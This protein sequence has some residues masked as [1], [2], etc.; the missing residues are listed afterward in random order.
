M[1]VWIFCDRWVVLGLKTA[2]RESEMMKSV[3][4]DDVIG[5]L[6]DFPRQAEI[7]RSSAVKIDADEWF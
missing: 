5:R 2:L 1:G 7:V 4:E 6:R 3:W